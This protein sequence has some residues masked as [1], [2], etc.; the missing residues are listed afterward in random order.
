MF[1][2]FQAMYDEIANKVENGEIHPKDVVTHI[3]NLNGN[4]FKKKKKVGGG[5]II[6]ILSSS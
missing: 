2:T 1:D 5:I 6:E 3:R 4:D